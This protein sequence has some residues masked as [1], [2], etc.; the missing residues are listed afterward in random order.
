MLDYQAT[1]ACRMEFLLRQLDDPNAAPCGRCDNCTG[2]HWTGSVSAS[3]AEAAR[4]RLHRP[5]VAV[6]PRKLWP[7]GLSTLD[8]PLSGK[9]APRDGAREGRAL[10]RLTDIGWGTRLRDLL[11]GPDTEIPDDVFQAC[12]Q[13]LAAWEWKERPVGVV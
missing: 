12:V 9:I 2:N 10:A 5:G 8:V 7:S 13:V 3:Y 1:T 4:E 11:A 6:A